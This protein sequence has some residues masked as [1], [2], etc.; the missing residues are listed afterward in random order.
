[1]REL[2]DD[3][4]ALLMIASEF[5]ELLECDRVLVMAAGRLMTELVG[6]DI[7]ETRMLHAAYADIT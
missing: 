4:L 2:A 5:E 7:N 6:E 3:G 1:M